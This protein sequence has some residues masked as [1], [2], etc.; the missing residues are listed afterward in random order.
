MSTKKYGDKQEEESWKILTH[1]KL[2]SATGEF[3]VESIQFLNLASCEIEDI[4]ALGN[5]L[6]L[7]RLDLRKNEISI[8]NPLRNLKLLTTLNL[9]ANRISNIDA[10]ASLEMLSDLNLSGNLIGSFERVQCLKSIDTLQKLRFYDSINKLSNPICHNISYEDKIMKILPSLVMLDGMKLKG[11]G[12]ELFKICADLDKQIKNAHESVN[13]AHHSEYCDCGCCS[14]EQYD[15]ET[16]F[17]PVEERA[18]PGSW[19][20]PGYFSL[21]TK[22]NKEDYATSEFKETLDECRRINNAAKEHVSSLTK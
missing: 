6:N 10:L 16:T 3:D 11:G 20:M 21:P 18:I 17:G 19:L 7:V 22:N 5:C 4:S 14:D 15:D 9:S 8:L 13:T 1:S 12:S 2:L